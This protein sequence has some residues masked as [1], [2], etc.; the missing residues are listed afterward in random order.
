[1]RVY[2]KNIPGKFHLDLALYDRATGF[3]KTVPQ[4]EQAQ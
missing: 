4:Q 1:M 3:L 2:F